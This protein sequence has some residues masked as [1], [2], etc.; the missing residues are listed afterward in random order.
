[1]ARRAL[2]PVYP[3]ERTPGRPL[4]SSELVS[5][6]FLKSAFHRT[7]IV[8]VLFVEVIRHRR[9]AWSAPLWW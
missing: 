4:S 8:G 6:E 9:S 7:A 1:M 5:Q 3:Q 2:R